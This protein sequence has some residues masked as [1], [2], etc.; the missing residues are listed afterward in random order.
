[1]QPVSKRIGVLVLSFDGFSELWPP[2]FE[3]LFRCW[4]QCVYP[5]Y[6]MTNHKTYSDERVQSLKLGN[7][8]SWSDNL[9]KALHSIPEEY[10]ILFYEDAFITNID[11]PALKK[12]INE[13]LR[14]NLSS[15]LMLPSRFNGRKKVKDYYLIN[16]DAPY[17]NS[18]FANLIRKDVLLTLLRS[19]ENAW[20]Y[21]V[22][23]NT[24]SR[25]YKFYCVT[26]PVFTYDHGIV[27]GKW[28]DKTYS[29]YVN[30]GFIFKKMNKH[31]SKREEFAYTVKLTLFNLYISYMPLRLLL[32]IEKYRCSEKKKYV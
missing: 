28:I 10:L 19:G 12:A 8:I 7:D 9:I 4:N 27:K 3:S 20:Q 26:K 15:M 5:I 18:L 11:H 17:R 16:P 21:E 6:L 1:M 31:F 25:Q 13:C 2:F 24:R 22:I 30:K 32:W 23:G 29:K 14:N